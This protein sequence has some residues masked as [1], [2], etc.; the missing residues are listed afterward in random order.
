VADD[1]NKPAILKG[2]TGGTNLMRGRDVEFMLKNRN[3]DPALVNVLVKIAEINHTNTLA[4]AELATLLD[5]MT[6]IMQGFSE[7]AGN[8]KDTIAQFKR[9]AEGEAEGEIPN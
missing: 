2:P 4:I 8:M 9:G 7:V 1:L 5:Q 3:L 6:T